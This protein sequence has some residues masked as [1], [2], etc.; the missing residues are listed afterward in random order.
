MRRS[1]ADVERYIASVQSS[2]PSP[3]EVSGAWRAGRPPPWPCRGTA[4]GRRHGSRRPPLP[5]ALRR[6]SARAVRWA[7]WRSRAGGGGGSPRRA[8]FG[9]WSSSSSWPA[10]DGLRSRAHPVRG[11]F[12]CAR[13]ASSLAFRRLP[14]AADFFLCPGHLPAVVEAASFRLWRSMEPSGGLTQLPG[15]L[16]PAL[17]GDRRRHQADRSWG[18]YSWNSLTTHMTLEVPF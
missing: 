18:N 15:G 13:A 6:R 1:K 12:D 4:Q 2:V 10:P 9:A 3:R 7:A 11:F 17:T 14:Y 5:G 16:F 8:A